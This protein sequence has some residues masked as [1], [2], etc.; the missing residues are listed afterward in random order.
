M[1]QS[2]SDPV[3]SRAV[4]RELW[5]ERM[6]R[7]AQSGM[8]VVAFCQQEGISSHAFYYWRHKL[9][10]QVPAGDAGQPRL[11]P[12]R[13]LGAAPV[14]LLLPNGCSLRLAPGC[15]LAFVRSLLGAL[16]DAPC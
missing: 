16:G 5:A 12:V 9:D 4:T 14:E 10:P 15:D 1:S 8:T 2:E 7:F 3:R 11:L 6:R 13:L